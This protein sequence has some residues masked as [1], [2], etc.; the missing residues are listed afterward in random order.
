MTVFN[1]EFVQAVRDQLATLKPGFY[2]TREQVCLALNVP[3]TYSNAISI[4]F[5]AG[6]F[7]E[8]ET[9]RSR[10]IRRRVAAQAA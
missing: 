9:V 7:P 10:G 4:L 8:Y 5:E 6:E 1:L 3:K 2:L